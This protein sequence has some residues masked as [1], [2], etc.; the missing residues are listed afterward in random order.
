MDNKQLRKK[1]LELHFELSGGN[2]LNFVMRTELAEKLGIDYNDE[3]LLSAIKYLEDKNL[4]KAETNVEDS[5]TTWGIDEV[6]KG[7]PAFKTGAEPD[8]TGVE[9]VNLLQRVNEAISLGKEGLLRENEATAL[10]T[11]GKEI[12]KKT[13][14]EK[15]ILYRKFDKEN[16]KTRWKTKS[17]DGYL[18]PTDLG[19]LQF[20]KKY[21]E[22][23]LDQE[24]EIIPK[25]RVIKTGENYTA[26]KILRSIL[27]KAKQSISIQDNF[28]DYT[29]F[30]LLE[31]YKESSPELDVRILTTGRYDGAFETD[32]EAFSKQYSKT[33]ARIHKVKDC[34]DRYIITDEKEVYHSGHSLKDLGNKLS[35]INRMQD[36]EEKKKVIQEYERWWQNGTPI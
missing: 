34:H 33:E 26:R 7:L 20:V 15:S 8:G 2:S 21:I 23:V 32:L 24:K 17:R 19:E 1:V 14:D 36:E 16:R 12:L 29:L 10:E 28:V 9:L 25:E 11:Q 4:L 31:P 30:Q 35:Q 5:I 13:I 27:S 18:N 6:E 3:R 22:E